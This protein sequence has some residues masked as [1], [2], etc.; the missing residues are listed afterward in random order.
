MESNGKN[1]FRLPLATMN[2]WCSIES[3]LSF[4]INALNFQGTGYVVFHFPAP[5]SFG[6]NRSH[7]TKYIAERQARISRDWFTILMGAVSYVVFAYRYPAWFESLKELGIS[8]AW[9]ASLEASTVMDRDFEHVGC[10]MIMNDKTRSHPQ[11]SLLRQLKV[12]MWFPW[13]QREIDYIADRLRRHIVTD[14]FWYPTQEELDNPEYFNYYNDIPP[15]V[16]YRHRRPF[17]N[18]PA[19]RRLPTPEPVSPAIASPQP[20]S[21]RANSPMAITP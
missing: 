5:S 15:A 17:Y 4:V 9:I 6:Y 16:S 1:G 3:D 2:A 13:G 10:F 11:G 8:Q 19:F 7:K 12:P 18:P 20:I 14:S 21:H